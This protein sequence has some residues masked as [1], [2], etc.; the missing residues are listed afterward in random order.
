MTSLFKISLKWVK[1][2]SLAILVALAQLSLAEPDDNWKTPESVADRKTSMMYEHY[3]R[4]FMRAPEINPH[5]L[6]FRIRNNIEQAAKGDNL[7]FHLMAVLHRDWVEITYPE[8]KSI[9]DQLFEYFLNNPLVGFDD[10]DFRP[11][12]IK[13]EISYDDCPRLKS[14]IYAME[15]YIKSS[16]MSD[17]S[18][19]FDD[20]VYTLGYTNFDFDIVYE[21]NNEKESP[22]SELIKI[23][24]LAI[25][26]AKKLPTIE[27]K[28]R[29]EEV[30]RRK[31]YKGKIY[32]YPPSITLKVGEESH[33]SAIGTFCWPIDTIP[34]CSD[35]FSHITN[36]VP[37]VVKRGSILSFSIPEENELDYIEYSVSKVKS[38]DLS[39]EIDDHVDFL[40]WDK[41]LKP[42][43]SSVKDLR[44]ITLDKRRGEYI[45]VLFGQWG[46]YGD[47]LHGFYVKV[48]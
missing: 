27:E 21:N 37:I 29:L 45:I 36:K 13:K 6:A 26:C 39:K 7:E 4:N 20:N 8:G 15:E 10:F 17:V 47:S 2:S 43:K 3:L 11:K 12:V 19:E 44:S 42:I 24:E 22:F 25:K 32:N 16:L 34:L 31:N 33:E 9:H 23:K 35:S 46:L 14:P 18:H 5:N 30:D 28:R 40:A 1:V 41:K 38:S 48:E